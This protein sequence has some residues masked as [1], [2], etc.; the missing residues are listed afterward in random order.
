MIEDMS[1]ENKGSESVS[2]AGTRARARVGGLAFGLRV[3]DRF[4][5]EY[6]RVNCVE[7][8]LGIWETRPLLCPH[9]HFVFFVWHGDG[10]PTAGVDLSGLGLGLRLG[11]G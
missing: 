7:R 5:V 8:V 10:E 1:I 11:L 9:L 6:L 2:G 4:K 3:Q